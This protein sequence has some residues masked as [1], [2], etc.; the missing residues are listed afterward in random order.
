MS[1]LMR[2]M[3][4]DGLDKF[5]LKVGGSLEDDRR[6]LKIARDI[7]GYSKMLMV[8][9]NQVWSVP[10]AIEYMTQLAEFQPE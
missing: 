7:I 3:L 6:R 5:K 1:Q 2:G 4:E 8:D 10:D 9:A